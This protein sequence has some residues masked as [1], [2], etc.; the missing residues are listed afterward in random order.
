M[1]RI[2]ELR[3][4][5]QDRALQALKLKVVYPNLFDKILGLLYKNREPLSINEACEL[6]LLENEDRAKVR[7]IIKKLAAWEFLEFVK[8]KKQ[9]RGAYTLTQLG[10]DFFRTIDTNLLDEYTIEAI[11]KKHGLKMLSA[12]D[13]EGRTTWSSLRKKLDL[14]ESSMLNTVRGLE[15]A[16]LIIKDE[17]GGY[18]ITEKG[19]EVIAE[20][21]K[22]SKITANP[23]FEIQLKLAIQSIDNVINSIK[24]S[25]LSVV[26][27][28]FV[29]QKDYYLVPLQGQ[30]SASYLR[31]RVE[32]ELDK[33]GRAIKVPRYILTWTEKTKPIIHRGV[34][35]VSRKREE[36]EV[37][38]PSVVFFLEYLGAK[39]DKEIEKKRRVFDIPL[40]PSDSMKVYID[41]LIRAEKPRW[42]KDDYFVEIKASAWNEEEAYSKCELILE[43]LKTLGLEKE[44]RVESLYSEMA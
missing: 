19:K 43:M 31:Y 39:I 33:R 40:N 16:N 44:R 35:V 20:F 17:N 6:L 21:S 18:F 11:V 7:Y 26:K 13:G 12:L 14:S 22:L 15:D 42:E 9:G 34:Y 4:I 23:K 5:G 27:E 29:H 25:D 28:S 1:Q 2:Q 8:N 10:I 32:R 37:R 36:I 41:E 3:E 38:Y 24:K 30:N